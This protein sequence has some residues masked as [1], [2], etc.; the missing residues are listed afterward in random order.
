VRY[1]GPA[2]RLGSAQPLQ[3]AAAVPPAPPA[4]RP[5]P[6]PE[7]GAYWI[8]AGAFSDR[9]A[10]RRVADRL[11]D[12]ATVDVASRGDSPVYRVLVGPWA[13]PNA[14]ESA[15][16]AVVARGYADALLISGR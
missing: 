11:G 2:P 4:P 16:Q 10:A 8:Q 13:D 7:V 12:R 1:L 3:Y 5:E 14:A 15:R 6:A 9:R